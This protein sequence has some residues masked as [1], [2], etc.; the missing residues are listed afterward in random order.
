MFKV[1][2]SRGKPSTVLGFVSVAF[3]AATVAF[4]YTTYSSGEANIMAYGTGIM[5]ILAPFVAREYQEK[6]NVRPKD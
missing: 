3:F 6:S 2:D 5:T 4:L 1:K